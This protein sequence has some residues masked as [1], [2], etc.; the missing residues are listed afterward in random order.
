MMPVQVFYNTNYVSSGNPYLKPRTSHT[1]DV[2][3]YLYNPTKMSSIGINSTYNLYNTNIT[4]N[5]VTV[6]QPDK[7]Y[8]TKVTNENTTGGF[9][10][11]NWIWASQPLFKTKINLSPSAGLTYS[12]TPSY[13]NQVLNNT[14]NTSLSFNLR[15]SY[16]LGSKLMVN[17]NGDVDYTDVSYDNLEALSQTY[18]NYKGGFGIKWNFLPFAFLETNA[19]INYYKNTSLNFD[20]NQ[21][22]WNASVRRIFGKN[23]EFELR[24]S[25]FDVLN[26]R[27]S[28]TQSASNN[29]VFT[30]VAPTLAR[31]LMIGL[32][33]NTRGQEAKIK[34]ARMF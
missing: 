18:N 4:Q 9:D 34:K 20:R 26:Q 13:I 16:S 24:M 3:L 33:Y 25:V 28:I 30:Q 23:N 5:Q 2:S 14:K 6:Y 17:A 29:Q 21:I 10:I 32:T 22:I 11:A 31:Y 12:S 15:V 7:G 1:G 19:D 27:V 8:V